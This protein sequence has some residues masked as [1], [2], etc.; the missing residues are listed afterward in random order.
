INVVALKDDN[1]GEIPEMIRWAH[2]QSMDLTLIET[3]PL[4]EIDAERT[5]QYLSLETVRRSLETQWSLDPLTHRTGGPARYFR[6]RETGGRLGLITP[7]SHRF[8]EACN[9]VRVT[10]TG[11]LFQCLGQDDQVDLRSVMR[12]DADPEVLAQ[13]IRKAIAA[14]PKGHDFRIERPGEGPSV[15]RPMSMTGG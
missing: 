9:R 6:I 13:A 12:Q 5:D 3:M 10:C 1:A 7:M 2:Q 14:K 11:Q 8:C 15:F 4:G